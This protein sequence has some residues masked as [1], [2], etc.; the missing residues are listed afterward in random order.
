MTT[1]HPGGNGQVSVVTLP[2]E[3]DLVTIGQ[4]RDRLLSSV[5]R[6]G[7]H[8]VVDA[9]GTV[10]M[11]STGVNTLVRVRERTVRLGGSLH[12]VTRSRAVLRVL[13]ITQLDRVLAVVPSLDEAL[14][15]ASHPET[16]HTCNGALTDDLG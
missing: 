1:D 4:V 12:V 11:D 8:L 3:V 14:R 9:S 13:A 10:F 7:I 2:D 6:G 15:C 16:I 5:N